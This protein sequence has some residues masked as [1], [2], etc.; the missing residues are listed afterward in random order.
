MRDLMAI[1]ARPEVI[2]LAG[3]LPDTSTF[4]PGVVRGGHPAHRRGVLRAGA[5]V[6][7]H[8]GSRRDQG[9]HRRGDGRRG[10]ARGRRRPDRDH[11]RPAGDRPGD[12]G[13]DRPRRRGDRRG[14]DLP[15]RG[16]RVLVLPGRRGPDRHGLRG[17]ARGPAREHA[18]PARARGPHAE[19]RLH[20][21]DVPESRRGHALGGAAQAARGGGARARAARARGQPLRPA[22]IR[23]PAARAALRDR[24]RRVR[25]V[26]RHVLEDAV[27][28]HQ[29]RLG[30]RS[31]TRC[32]RRSTSASRPRTCARPRSRS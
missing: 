9:L 19:V 5:P 23:G 21:A 18:R 20:R 3:G 4:P 30:G 8:G 15:G 6:R 14:P 26:P 25:D 17:N 16:A 10:H 29:A 27:A 11:R 31:R 1:T 24:R 28:R 7:P 22:A 13:A 32:S 2:S 12:Q